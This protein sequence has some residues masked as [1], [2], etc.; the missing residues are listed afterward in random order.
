MRTIHMG[1]TSS[2]KWN[3]KITVNGMDEFHRKQ[4]WPT[5]RYYS[6]IHVEELY[7][8]NLAIS[9]RSS[10]TRFKASTFK[11][12]CRMLLLH[13]PMVQQCILY[14]TDNERNLWHLKIQ[15]PVL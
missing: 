4:L 2:I 3:R 15:K 13:Q 10:I 14:V 11:A 1:T 5:P 9:I 12:K 8:E 7:S 6:S